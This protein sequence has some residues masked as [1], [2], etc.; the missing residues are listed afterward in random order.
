MTS[1]GLGGIDST[2]LRAP[3]AEYL[4][5]VARRIEYLA[6]NTEVV[7]HP[8]LGAALLALPAMLHAEADLWEHNYDLQ[9]TMTSLGLLLVHEDGLCAGLLDLRGP[10]PEDSPVPEEDRCRHYDAVYRLAR[11]VTGRDA[12]HETGAAETGESQP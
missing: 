7:L 2:G 3:G 11:A 10:L 1:T 12:I 6:R 9:P 8:S 5:A 4:R